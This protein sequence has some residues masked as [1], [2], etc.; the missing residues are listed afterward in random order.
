MIL[1]PSSKG[2]FPPRTE[3]GMPFGIP[4]FGENQLQPQEEFM[5]VDK[6]QMLADLV[7]SKVKNYIKERDDKLIELITAIDLKNGIIDER[8]NIMSKRI[9]IQEDINNIMGGN[10]G[11]IK[12]NSGRA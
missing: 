12:G 3:E 11:D 9:K 7:V 6:D 4:F 8:L 2:M 10:Y 5:E 1:F